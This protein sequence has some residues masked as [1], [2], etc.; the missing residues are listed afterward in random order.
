MKTERNIGIAFVLNLAF[1]VLETVGGLVTGSVAIISDAIH[2]LGDALSIGVSYILE[3]KSR[4][5]PDAVYTYGYARYSVI[6]SAFT[7]LIL[8]LGSAAVIYGAVCRLIAP[9]PIDYNGMILFAVVG[10]TV[11]LSAAFVTRGGESLNQKAVNLHMLEDVLGW[12][13]V[14]VGAA[15]MRFTDWA[16]LDP[17]LSIAVAIFIL[18]HAVHNAKETIDVLLEK[19]PTDLS[20]P[21]L[22]EHLCE[23]EGVTDVHHIH[24]WS[25]DKH[26]HIATLHVVSN[27][28]PAAIKARIREELREHGIGHATVEVESVGEACEAK[29]CD[30][31]YTVVSHHHHHH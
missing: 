14:L 20:L 21:R 30:T 11:N 4:A 13:A 7:T 27:D 6:G 22:R 29:Q 9:S 15:V 16:V 31:S 26:C 24:V 1:A 25:M 8:I 10:V 23:L 12:V 2:D 19:I 5:K 3:R 18:T 28:E 17:L